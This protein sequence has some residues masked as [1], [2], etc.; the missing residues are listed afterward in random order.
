VP[1]QVTGLTGITQIA[2]GAFFALA[3]RSD[4]TVWAWGDNTSGQLGNGSTI[5]SVIPVQVPGLS[6]VT[7]IAAGGGTALVAR[8]Q[9][10]ITSLT[11]VW[12]WG[13]NSLGQLGDGTTTSRS[14]P[15]QVNGISVPGIRQIAEGGFFSLVLGSDG[16]VWGWGADQFSQL[17]NTATFDWTVPVETVGMD[18]GITQI[19]AGFVHTLALKSDGSVIAWGDD[20]DGEIGH[21]FYADGP[22][23]ATQ[24]TGLTNATQVSAGGDFSLAVHTVYRF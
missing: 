16:S 23:V 3:L 2:V 18:S 15:E 13:D 4:G 12:T 6:R 5:S 11:T 24:V 21:G 17:G 22:I 7:Q 9:G 19:S 1:V 14:T 10:F 8:T 20:Q